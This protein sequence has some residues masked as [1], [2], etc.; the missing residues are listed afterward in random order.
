MKQIKIGFSGYAGSGKDS[1][2]LILSTI[3]RFKGELDFDTYYR[4]RHIKPLNVYILRFGD[5]VKV[6]ARR[7]F[8]LDYYFFNYRNTKECIV[9]LETSKIVIDNPTDEEK[10]A[11][12]YRYCKSGND[13]PAQAY[14][15]SLLTFTGDLLKATFGELYWVNK[16]ETKIKNNYSKFEYILIPDVRYD[17]E[18][19]IT[20]ININIINNKFG[21]EG[22]HSSEKRVGLRDGDALIVNY[23]NEVLLFE[24]LLQVYNDKIKNL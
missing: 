13:I 11:N 21:K 3:I 5:D 4:N 24:S 19:D 2:A 6:I 15:R 1:A 22:E 7:M 12:T 9:D 16:L 8:S 14:S 18:R 20:D 23:E 17:Y 10:V